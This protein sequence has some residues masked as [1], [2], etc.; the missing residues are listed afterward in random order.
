MNLAPELV[1]PPNPN[2]LDLSKTDVW[3]TGCVFFE[4]LEGVHP[5]AETI[6][7]D[8]TLDVSISKVS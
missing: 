1:K 2:D 7:Y 8:S 3:A 6:E 4:I 5:L